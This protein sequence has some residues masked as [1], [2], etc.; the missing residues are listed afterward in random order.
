MEDQEGL[1]KERVLEM[2][3]EMGGDLDKINA[4]I[5]ANLFKR[6]GRRI[7]IFGNFIKSRIASNPL[8][9]KMAKLEITPEEAA[10]LSQY[11]DLAQL[12][13]LD[14]R[15]NKLC[16]EGLDALAH[17]EILQ[18]LRE[19]DLRNNQITRIGME[20][21]ARSKTLSQLEKLDLRSNK[22]GKRWEEKLRG[23]EIFQNLREVRT[24]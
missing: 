1:N 17:S 16:D 24:L 8:V 14:L 23:L 7:A 21:L 10:Y 19:L 2:F 15:Q 6:K 18:N 4:A 12:E 13:V 22:L 5:D 9:L 11:P 3:Y 20:S